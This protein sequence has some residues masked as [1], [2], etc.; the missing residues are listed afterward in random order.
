MGDLDIAAYSGNWD[1]TRRYFPRRA[2]VYCY[3]RWSETFVEDEWHI[4]LV[5]PLYDGLRRTLPFTAESVRVEGHGLQGAGC[6]PRNLLS[7]VRSIMQVP[8]FVVVADFLLQAQKR[9]RD[10]RQQHL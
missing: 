4:F 10:F 7:L 9:R 5:C 2:C 8:R 1:L 6:T 3:Q